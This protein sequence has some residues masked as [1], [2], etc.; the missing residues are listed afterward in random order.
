MHQKV[1]FLLDGEVINIEANMSKIESTVRDDQKQVVAPPSFQVAMISDRVEMDPKVL[2]MIKKMN[3]RPEQGLGKNEQGNLELPDFKG[4][5][6]SKGLGYTGV[7]LGSK[8]ARRRFFN[9]NNL[10]KNVGPLKDNFV[11]EGKGNFYLGKKE[12]IEV[13]GVNILGFEIF[14][15]QIVE[16]LV[17]NNKEKV[18]KKVVEKIGTEVVEKLLCLPTNDEL[19]QD[20]GSVISY[21]F[22]DFMKKLM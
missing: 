20:L 1:K 11:K 13:V 16:S 18:M 19:P 4:Q 5:G 14:K 3:Y 12:P 2:S 6:D 7:G 8:G 21:S 10:L 9:R 22:S 17:R 15:E